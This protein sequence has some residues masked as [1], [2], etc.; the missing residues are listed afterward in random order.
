M[1]LPANKRPLPVEGLDIRDPEWEELERGPGQGPS[2]G[3]V[4]FWDHIHGYIKKEGP[5]IQVKRPLRP[6]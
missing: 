6:Y 5:K 4:V 2:E 3:R 1:A